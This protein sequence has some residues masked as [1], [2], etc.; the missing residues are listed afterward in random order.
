MFPSH[1]H[2]ILFSTPYH[3][4]L[5]LSLVRLPDT[6][7]LPVSDGMKSKIPQFVASSNVIHSLQTGVMLCSFV[8]A[9]SLLQKLC[10]DN[11]IGFVRFGTHAALQ[12]IGTALALYL[13]LSP[14]LQ[15]FSDY[16]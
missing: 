14:E 16:R 4:R 13:M 5:G 10:D 15:S 8:A 2:L 7:Y 6:F 9:V 1:A 11:K 12:A 3:N